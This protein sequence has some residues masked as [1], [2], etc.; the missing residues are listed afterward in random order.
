MN[1]Y[2]FKQEIKSR[3][4]RA[5]LTYDTHAFVQKQACAFLLENLKRFSDS[6]FSSIADYGSGTGEST[7]ALIKAVDFQTCCAIDFSKAAL[8]FSQ[9]KLAAYDLNFLCT[10]FENVLFGPKK[11]DLIFSNMSFQWLKSWGYLFLNV[12][13]SLNENGF[14]V[15]STPL[16]GNFP[17]LKSEYRHD[18]FSEVEILALL[19]KQGFE[20][21][22][23]TNQIFIDRFSTPVQSLR[24]LKNTGVNVSLNSNKPKIKFQLADYFIGEDF[25]LS[26]KIGFFIARKK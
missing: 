11:L 5:V 23:H 26:Y 4:E 19:I 2:H 10:D 20:V 13:D 16:A 18:F 8:D 21:V 24:S 15:F 22:F 1:S 7:I 9:K 17:E 12:F 6:R 3:V 25:S 14:L